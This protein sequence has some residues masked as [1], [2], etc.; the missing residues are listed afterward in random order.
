MKPASNE[1]QLNS[2]KAPRGQWETGSPITCT[3]DGTFQVKHWDNSGSTLRDFWTSSSCNVVRNSKLKTKDVIVFL[4]FQDYG[5]LKHYLIVKYNQSVFSTYRV[6]CNGCF[7]LK[8]RTKTCC[9]KYVRKLIIFSQATTSCFFN[10]KLIYIYIYLER[11]G[12]V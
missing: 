1:K 4:W 5:A 2:I 6:F 8:F 7:F 9:W 10:Q 11:T 12:W 3:P